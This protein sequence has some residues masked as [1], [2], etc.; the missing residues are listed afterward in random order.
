MDYLHITFQEII[1]EQK[2]TNI[3]YMLLAYA[4]LKGVSPT[5]K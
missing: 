4:F 3:R 5:A 2:Q 1:R